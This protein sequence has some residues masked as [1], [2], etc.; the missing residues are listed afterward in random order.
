MAETAPVLLGGEWRA[1]A[2]TER[3]QKT[4][5]IDGS[6]LGTFPISP[7]SEVSEALDNG[8]AAYR[9]LAAS[10][11]DIF[12]SFLERFSELID[13]AAEE[14]AAAAHAE[15]ALPIKPR[16][17]DMEL[18][19]TSGQLRQ[20]AAAARTRT[21]MLPTVNPEAWIASYFAP[22][23]GPVVVF[24]PSNFPFAFNSLAGGDFAAAIAT[25]HPVI[26]KA[27]PGHPATTG[28]LG[29]LAQE[30]AD[31]SRLPPD[32]VQLIYHTAPEDGARLVADQRI[33]ATAFTGSRT[34]GLALKEAADSAGKPIYLEMSSNNPVVI[35]PSALAERGDAIATELAASVLLGGGQFCTSP[36]LLLV[37]SGSAGD[38]FVR[39]LAQRITEAP[40]QPLL[41][42]NIRQGLESCYRRWEECGAQL[43]AGSDIEP[44]FS[45][46]PNTVMTV[47]D[48]TFLTSPKVLQAEAFGNMTLVVRIN[49]DDGLLA[50]IQSL[51]GGLTGS[52]YSAFDGADDT[53][54]QVIAPVLRERVGRFLNDKV[55]T[56]VAVVDAM[57]HGG[58]YPATGHPGFT[59][60]G[61]PASLRRFGMLQSFDGVRPSRLPP[62]LRPNNPLSIQRFIAGEWTRRA[63]SP[64]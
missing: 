36:G 58:P 31:D 54:Y 7:W 61:I 18:P 5:P 29:G 63:V 38:D 64:G 28:I 56:G 20:A 59:A 9:Q 21:W 52:I 8:V 12:A 47:D 55:P 40:V 44:S 50:V 11:P 10:E 19:R 39:A 22:I 1:S 25:G 35:L 24:G 49:A 14:L 17:T 4:S 2:G 46:F 30:A 13:L 23:P 53:T 48:H 60:V 32:L 6:K 33:A 26:A 57:H 37:P 45:I 3:Y 41:N 16:L 62:E 51:E 42:D 27:N 43:V 34:G 15:T